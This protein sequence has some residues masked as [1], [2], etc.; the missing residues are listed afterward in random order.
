MQKDLVSEACL[1]WYET[2]AGQYAQEQLIQ[3]INDCLTEIFG[4]YA[5]E[6]GVL[7]G[8]LQ[9]LNEARIGSC[10]SVGRAGASVQAQ[11]EN[12]PIA[13]D[14]VDL[15]IASH[16]LETSSNPHQVLRE[17]DR[18]LVPE[19][20]CILIGFNALRFWHK[21]RLLKHKM[22][23][24]KEFRL[25]GGY[26]VKDWFS[27]LG[28]EVQH[29]EYIGFRPAFLKDSFFQRLMWLENWGSRYLPV[30]GSL[31]VVH[32]QKQVVSMTRDKKSWSTAKVL[33]TTGKVAVNSS[34]GVHH[35]DNRAG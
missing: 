5:L 28:F 16:V 3:Q 1:K 19:G 20:H 23:D 17:I 14:N 8:N 4:Y 22:G 2:P 11:M 6:T 30:F 9:L 26:R 34:R 18:V 33:P 15:V 13:F 12:L 32:A 25:Y 29:V 24:A 10:F 21:N 27:L 35:R 31:Y 7:A